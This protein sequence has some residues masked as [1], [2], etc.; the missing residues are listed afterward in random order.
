MSTGNA[1]HTGAETFGTVAVAMVTP[2]TSEGEL[3]IAAG[4]RLAQHLVDKGCDALILAG[5]TGESPT[6][7]TAEKLALLRAVRAELPDRIR[8]IAGV[9]TYNTHASL[10]LA[11][12]S[13]AAGASALLAVT[14]YYSKPS[15]EDLYQHFTAI[16]DATD[17]P[18]CLYDIPSR[19]VISIASDTI[20]RL[21]EHRNIQAMKD[22][23]G[24]IAAAIPLIAETGLAWYSG[25]DPLNLPW[26]SVGATGFISVIGHI[27]PHLLRELYT[28]FEEGD[29]ARAR[30]LN[31]TV[32]P[33][34]A[35]QARLGGVSL[36]KAALG[37]QG[38]D[39]GVPRLPQV[40]ADPQ[41]LEELRRDLEK[42][43][44]LEI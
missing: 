26:L 40:P 19:S 41:Q 42:V 14:P 8:L 39:V 23:K 13:A 28:C 22:A 29:L 1:V 21:A 17:L 37:L 38:I 18:V 33:L 44:V 43:G 24:D 20:K 25:D 34:F 3:D 27:V 7:T 31:A 2:F 11:R 30:E 4:V 15:Q 6:T 10:E 5:T 12:V 9:S 36:A 16:A 35:A 32:S